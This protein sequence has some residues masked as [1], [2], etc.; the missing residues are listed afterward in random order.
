MRVRCLSSGCSPGVCNCSA[1]CVRTCCSVPERW[2]FGLLGR[3]MSVVSVT[4]CFVVVTQAF[5][6]ALDPT[7]VQARALGS[8]CGAAG[9][10]FNWGLARC[11]LVIDRDLNAAFN[12]AALVQTVGAGDDTSS[13][14]C[15]ATQNEP[16]GN[17]GKT[18]H[19]GTGYRHGKTP[20][21]GANAATAR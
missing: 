7:P 8:H 18:S 17:P 1:S 15:G 3:E 5:R 6:F 4:V 19:A 21:V 12:L 9:F 14:S 13:Q 20:T 2:R 11:G 10:A 16:A